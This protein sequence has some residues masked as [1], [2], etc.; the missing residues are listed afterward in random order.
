VS[1]K[2]SFNT[3][4]LQEQLQATAD[5]MHKATRPAAQAGVQLIY[6]R[7]RANAPVSK[8][9]HYFH[10]EGRKYGPFQPGNLRDSIYQVFSRD[11]SFRDVSTYEV[12]WNKTKAPYGFAY[13]YGNSKRGAKS[14]IA[15]SV[16]ETRKEVRDTIKSRFI[17]EVQS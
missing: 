9:A 5:K 14:F 7:A 1:L 11:K 13:E 2:I 8:K 17:S 3:K 10:I 16:A 4:Q 15:R 6:D 12:S